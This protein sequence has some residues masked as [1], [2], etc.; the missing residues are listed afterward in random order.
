[1][2]PLNYQFRSWKFACCGF[3][4][5][6][7]IVLT[8]VVAMFTVSCMA[9]DESLEYQVKAAF[10]LNFTKF[11]EWPPM[12]F[13]DAN[14]PVAICILGDD[15]FGSPL[16]KLVDGEMVGGRKVIVQRVR[17]AP[18]PGSCQVLF[19]SRG[20][21]DISQIPA[22]PGPGVLTVGESDSFLHDGGIVH[23]VIENRRVRFDINQAA[24][25]KAGLRISARLLNVARAVEK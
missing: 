25:E 8:A 5:K 20:V 2:E 17:R 1:M 11:V 18:Q 9:A 10:L 15:P 16:D 7:A 3:L 24:A 22:D 14:S 4:R 21:K 6:P 13:A 23:F 19:I 12:A